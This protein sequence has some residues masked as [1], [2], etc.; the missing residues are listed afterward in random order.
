M[1][2]EQYSEI[3]IF[4]SMLKE[5]NISF[6]KQYAHGGHRV[7]IRFEN[8]VIFSCI[9]HKHSYGGLKSIEYAV[10]RGFSVGEPVG[11]CTAREVY[12]VLV[13]LMGE[14]KHE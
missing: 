8:G 10:V 7:C 6:T 14:N 3:Q 12:D 13:E 1:S 5:N 2:E 11:Y 9:S 4:M